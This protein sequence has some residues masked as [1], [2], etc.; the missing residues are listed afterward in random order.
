MN[1]LSNRPLKSPQTPFASNP[2]IL[3]TQ[4]QWLFTPAELAHAPSILDGMPLET[5][6]TNRAKGVNF[7][8]QVG[9]ILKIPQLTLATASLYLHRFFMRHSMVDKPGRPGLHHYA[10]AATALFLATKVE[11]SCRKMKDLVVTYCRVAQKQPNLIVDESSKE[12]WRWRDTLLHNEDILLEALCFDL[13]LEQPYRLLFDFLC[14]YGVQ[15]NKNL[16]NAAW[17]FVN[18]SNLTTMRLQFSARTIA[19]SALYAAAKHT[20]VAFPDDDYGR[21]WWEHLKVDIEEMKKA[22][23]QLVDAYQKNR[24]PAHNEQGAYVV[25]PED[26]GEE[27]TKTRI[28]SDHPRL[29]SPA[30]SAESDNGSRKRP[31]EELSNVLPEDVL[32]KPPKSPDRRKSPSP[33]LHSETNHP[34]SPKKQRLDTMSNGTSH[35]TS[36]GQTSNQPTSGDDI[37]SRIDSIVNGSSAAENHTFALPSQHDRPP[38]SYQNPHHQGQRIPHQQQTL[39]QW[40]PPATKPS[41]YQHHRRRSRSRSRSRSRG[42]VPMK[43]TY[44]GAAGRDRGMAGGFTRKPP[45][46][47]GSYNSSSR[48]D[49]YDAKDGGGWDHNSAGSRRESHSMNERR[50]STSS[51]KS[52]VNGLSRTFSHDDA[53]GSEEGELED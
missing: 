33:R 11:E 53:E 5:E 16:R 27:A 10:I 43:D 35:P 31:R 4:S 15:D 26:T 9:A 29:R 44:I 38:I 12:Y 52:E 19:A 14:Y 8:L 17:A 18:D 21:P 7:I 41:D 20:D 22:C 24:L 3:R 32:Q 49:S 37:Q 48:R 47:Q 45:D 13:Q 36:N 42:R 25:T 6:Q 1:G 28:I 51:R 39:Q 34:P 40:P 23:N 46:R 2:V 50:G 30:L